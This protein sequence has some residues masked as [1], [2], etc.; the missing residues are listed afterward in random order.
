MP[1]RNK[2]GAFLSL[3]ICS[4]VLI[5]CGL[6]PNVEYSGYKFNAGTAVKAGTTKVLMWN[7]SEV[8]NSNRDL[9]YFSAAEKF[10]GCKVDSETAIFQPHTGT[11]MISMTANL[12]C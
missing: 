7:L 9:V 12:T 1:R 4:V 5:G 10:S 11:S 8:P 2:A 6:A 3:T